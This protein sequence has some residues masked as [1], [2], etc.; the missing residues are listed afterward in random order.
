MRNLGKR[1]TKINGFWENI[2]GWWRRSE[3]KKTVWCL[4]GEF[5]PP[6]KSIFQVFLLPITTFFLGK[7]KAPD[8]GGVRRRLFWWVWWKI[9]QKKKKKSGKKSDWKDKSRE[10]FT[11]KSLDFPIPTSGLKNSNKTFEPPPKK[12]PQI[13]GKLLKIVLKNPLQHSKIPNSVFSLKTAR[14]PH[15]IWLNPGVFLRLFHFIW[16][17]RSF[18]GGIFLGP[19]PF[20]G[21]F[22][23]PILLPLHTRGVSELNPEY[24]PTP[25]P[26][27]PSPFLELSPARTQ[28]L[29]WGRIPNPRREGGKGRNEE[30]PG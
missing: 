20:L 12:T 22:F 23:F 19:F 2:W 24:F 7:M 5:I 9:R 1:S 27:K 8:F 14:N 11:T 30:N 28:I 21:N 29:G 16:D 13:Y 15:Q 26:S 17:F 25:E 3:K 6:K 4:G 10:E 18:S